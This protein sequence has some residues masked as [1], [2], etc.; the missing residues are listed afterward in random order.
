MLAEGIQVPCVHLPAEVDLGDIHPWAASLD[1]AIE[2]V[3][4][5]KSPSF[6][7]FVE[8]SENLKSV[9]DDL[10]VAWKEKIDFWIAYPKKPFFG[11]DLSSQRALKLMKKVGAKGKREEVVDET[12]SAIYF[13]RGKVK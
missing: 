2:L 3:R 7:V 10:K 5:G 12:W 4:E 1:S 9:R 11:T 13:R 6:L 8:N